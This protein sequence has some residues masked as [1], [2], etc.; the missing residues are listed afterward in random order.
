[1]RLILPLVLLLSLSGCSG[2]FKRMHAWMGVGQESVLRSLGRQPDA[3][4]QDAL[5]EWMRWSRHKDGGCSDRFTFRDNRVVGYA[6][7]CGI[8]GGFSAPKAPTSKPK[9]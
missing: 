5:G 1:M 4:G 7:D 9:E 6:S 2:T 8:W 3:T